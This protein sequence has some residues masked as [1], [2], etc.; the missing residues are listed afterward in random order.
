MQ[1]LSYHSPE[2][3]S[4]LTSTVVGGRRPIPLKIC[5][6][7]DPALFRTQRLRLKSAHSAS[8]VRGS[9]IVKSALIGSRQCAFNRAIDELCALPLSPT[10][11]GSK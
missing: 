9:E 1:T 3:V 10:K 7:S 4:F 5:A 8:T 6:Q 2:T 11:G